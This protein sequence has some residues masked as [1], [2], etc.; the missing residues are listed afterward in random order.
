MKQPKRRKRMDPNTL[1][2]I[3]RIMGGVLV[4]VFIVLLVLCTWYGTRIK[5][6]TITSVTVSGGETIS[7]ELVKTLV[8]A[9]LEGEY[10]RLIPKRFAFL[11]PKSSIIISLQDIER[12][13]YITVARTSLT[14]LSV[15]FKEYAPDALWC[16]SEDGHCVYVD[17]HG[18]AFGRAPLLKGGSFLRLNKLGVEPVS[19]VQAFDSENYN[20]I[21]DLVTLLESKNW[22]VDT[23][24]T[25]V[26]GD[27]YVLLAEGGE[28][29]VALQDSPEQ[30]VENLFTVLSSPDFAEITPGN[31]EYID[32]R[33]GN[34]VFVNEQE[35]EPEI[36]EELATT[37][38]D[39]LE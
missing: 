37:T 5:A 14:S 12:I 39:G 13:K 18:Y 36:E 24:Q 20:R 33:F 19:R 9:E 32:L 27:A 4:F 25:D 2:L 6:A 22:F 29:K 28:L 7:H 8:E 26:V 16:S 17:K 21:K 11:Y 35:P 34:K 38:V 31:F 3:Q 23:V 30:I 10:I 1:L 15:S